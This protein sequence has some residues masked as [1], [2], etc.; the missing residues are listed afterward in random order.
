MTA[1]TIETLHARIAALESQVTVLTMQAQIDAL[2]AKLQAAN[3]VAAPVNAPVNAPQRPALSEAD[4]NDWNDALAAM[5]A[6]AA[7]DVSAPQPDERGYFDTKLIRDRIR[8][9]K[10]KIAQH[11]AVELVAV[12][13]VAADLPY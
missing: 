8:V 9:T 11:K 1:H 10:L 5:R 6:E 7:D 12:E 13:L 2:T 3:N 4:R